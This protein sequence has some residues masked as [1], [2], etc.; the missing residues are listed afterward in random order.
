MGYLVTI[1]VLYRDGRGQ[2]G[3]HRAMA[4]HSVWQI[5][6]NDLD[7]PICNSRKPFESINRFPGRVP[8]PGSMGTASPRWA[9]GASCL[10]S[11][12]CLP[13]APGRHTLLPQIWSASIPHSSPVLSSQQETSKAFSRSLMIRKSS[14][15]AIHCVH[16]Y[17]I[18][19]S[20]PSDCKPC[21]SL[22]PGRLQGCLRLQSCTVRLA[23]RLQCLPP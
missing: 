16:S 11:W 4:G 19:F 2:T 21:F 14:F 5:D 10:P 6:E 7:I 8:Q 15:I 23:Q 12:V 17:S 13:S 9:A 18:S 3:P 1:S 20:D 22:R